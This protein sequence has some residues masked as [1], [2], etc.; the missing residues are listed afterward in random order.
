MSEDRMDELMSG[1][2]EE[3]ALDR[4]MPVTGAHFYVE[5]GDDRP[6]KD[7]EPPMTDAHGEPELRSPVT[8]HEGLASAL[9]LFIGVGLEPDENVTIWYRDN[10]DEANVY[11]PVLTLTE[12]PW[13]AEIS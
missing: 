10:R 9:D 1:L 6:A 7:G 13:L 2:T 4:L 11:H 5:T 12:H 3:Q 8:I